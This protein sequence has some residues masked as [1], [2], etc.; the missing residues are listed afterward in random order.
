MPCQTGKMGFYDADRTHL[1]ETLFQVFGSND[2]CFMGAWRVL[3]KKLC[4]T[5]AY[6]YIISDSRVHGKKKKDQFSLM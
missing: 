1:W 3:C 4:N 6:S 5:L 2:F